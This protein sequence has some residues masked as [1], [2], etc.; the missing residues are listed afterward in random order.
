MAYK[1]VERFKQGARV[2]QTTD[3]RHGEMCRNRRNK[4]CKTQVRQIMYTAH[5]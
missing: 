4:R 3:D 5:E 2:W 1:S